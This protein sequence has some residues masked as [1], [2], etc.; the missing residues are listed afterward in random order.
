MG[1]DQFKKSQTYKNLLAAFAGESQASMKYR[2]FASQ[3]KKE[4]LVH[5]SN[6]FEESSRNEKEHAE[7]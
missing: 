7:I 4:G 1:K 5:V 6:V 3:A 2:L